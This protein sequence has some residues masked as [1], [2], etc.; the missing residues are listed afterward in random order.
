MNTI[1]KLKW[2][3]L[4]AVVLLVACGE[5]EGS[6]APMQPGKMTVST[7]GSAP[8][9]KRPDFATLREGGRVFKQHCA[10]CHGE[11]GEGG[12]NW[13]QPGADGRYLA[14]PLNGTGHA[15]HHPLAVLR[16]V[17]R[18]GSPRDGNGQPT[19]NM[20]AWKEKLSVQE[21]EAVIAWFQNQWP[22]EIYDA[23]SQGNHRAMMSRK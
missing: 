1:P 17:I 18:T 11:R 9:R 5:Q 21:I 7:A 13:K 4:P 12:A 20:P 22:D 2:M 6:V 10:E 14:P 16:H 8:A 23:W 3:V 15:W 19:G